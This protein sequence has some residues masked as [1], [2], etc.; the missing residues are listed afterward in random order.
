MNI[1]A[2]TCF[3]TGI[4]ALIAGLFVLFRKKQSRL[5]QL[6]F[7][8]N[9]SIALWLMG[10][11]GTFIANNSTSALFWQRFLYIGTIFIPI[12][13]LRFCAILTKKGG[14]TQ[15]LLFK[16]NLLLATIFIISLFWG[17]FFIRYVKSQTSFG[18]WPVEVGWLYLPFLLWFVSNVV[19]AFLLLKKALQN[20][21][22][23]ILKKRQISIIFYGT[24][25]GFIAGSLNFLLDF[26]IVFPP[27]HNFFVISYLFFTALAITKYHLFEI[28]IILT[29]LLV[30]VMAIILVVLPFLMPTPS[31]RIFT[32]FIFF[33]FCVIGY[34]L[35]KAT[36]KEIERREKIEKLSQ[37]LNKLNQ[38][39]E[40][41]VKQRTKELE[42]AKRFAEVQREIAEERARRLEETH[43]RLLK[44]E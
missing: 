26:D 22:I 15:S 30:G 25:V 29:E 11:S 34:L 36:H 43:M 35:V 21:A 28:R 9:L 6:W 27:F 7:L 31:L 8:L 4:I 39:L 38:T 37:E 17:N 20:R 1:F 19:Y 41:K 2:L 23:D 3:I 12:F 44:K 13:F 40:Q 14:K 16:I 24:L 42:K 18:Y 10:L 32:A 33:I 5:N